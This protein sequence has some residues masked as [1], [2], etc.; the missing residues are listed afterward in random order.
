MQVSWDRWLQT[1]AYTEGLPEPKWFQKR[2]IY[3]DFKKA[4]TKAATAEAAAV[5]AEE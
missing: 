1:Q 4:A 2:E 3:A 5:S